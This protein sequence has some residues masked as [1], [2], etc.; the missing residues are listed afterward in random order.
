MEIYGAKFLELVDASRR[1]YHEFLAEAEESQHSESPIPDPNHSIIT[2]ISDDES[3]GDKD[4]QPSTSE[5]AGTRSQYF[6]RTSNSSVNFR[7]RG[8]VSLM[9]SQKR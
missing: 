5:S 3:E 8:N 4:Y 2:I 9:F 1:R 6:G 7:E